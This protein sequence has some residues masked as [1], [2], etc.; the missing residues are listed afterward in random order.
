[1]LYDSS[2]ASVYLDVT[3][4]RSILTLDS[5]STLEI[6]RQKS[7]HTELQLKSSYF[8]SNASEIGGDKHLP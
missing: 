1:M 6:R 8:D 4:K 5:Q 3:I 7:K 2:L